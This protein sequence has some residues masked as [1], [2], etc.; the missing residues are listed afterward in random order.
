MNENHIIAKLLET[1]E[2]VNIKGS[3]EKRQVTFK[4]T[5]IWLNADLSID[6]MRTRR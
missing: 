2:R 3:Q 4:G 1:K 5:T 6:T